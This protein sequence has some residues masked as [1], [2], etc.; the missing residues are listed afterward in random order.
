MSSKGMAGAPLS[1]HDWLF[2]EGHDL[3]LNFLSQFRQAARSHPVEVPS[4]R[5]QGFRAGGRRKMY[6]G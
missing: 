1:R 2:S 3:Q 4:L 5:L 6:Q